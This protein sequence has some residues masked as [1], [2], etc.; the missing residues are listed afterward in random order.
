[1]SHLYFYTTGPLPVN[2]PSYIRRK[3]DEQ[4]FLHLSRMEYISIIEPRQHGKTSLIIQ[5]MN[6]FKPSGYTFV[7]C[8]L[9]DMPSANRN[10]ISAKEWY[11]LLGQWIL[12]QLIDIIP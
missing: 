6:A 9:R 4:V 12:P 11:S 7:L 5:L 8:D 2:S 10:N 3:A 1:M